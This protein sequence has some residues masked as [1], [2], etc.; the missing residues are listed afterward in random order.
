MPNAIKYTTGTESLALKKG[1]FYIG[2]GDVGKGPTNVTGY[3]NGIT[4]PSGGY[5]I[6][7]NKATGGPSIFVANNDQQL[8]SLTNIIAD[9]SYATVSECLSYYDNQP[10]KYCTNRDYESISTDGLIFNMDPGYTASY[11]RG[12]T[13]CYDTST[14]GNNG[15]LINSPIF[16]MG[17]NYGVLSFDGIDDYIDLGSNIDLSGNC[18]FVLW[19]KP[20]I[21][22]PTYSV[23]MENAERVDASNWRIQRAG[24]GN[25]VQFY[26]SNYISGG[27][28]ITYDEYQQ[29]VIV[30]EY[31]SGATGTV[32]FYRNGVKY[33]SPGIFSY[34][35]NKY[36]TTEKTLIGKI[37]N[38]DIAKYAGDMG[39]VQIYDRVLNDSEVLNLYNLQ[40]SRFLI[41]TPTPTPSVTPTVTP[42][43]GLA[44]TPTPSP[45]PIPVSS[46]QLWLDASIASS[47]PGSGTV[48]YDLSGNG[49]NATLF[50]GPTSSN[51]AILFDGSN[52]Y[53]TYLYDAS[54]A[55]TIITIGY[56]RQSTWNNY[57]GLGSSRTV[58]GFIVHND[59]GT[60]VRYYVVSSAGA[61]TLIGYV[62]PAS[63]NVM[64]MYAMSTNGTNAHKRYLD[65]SL[66]GTD[67]TNL[68]RGTSNN[69][70][71]TLGKDSTLSRYNFLGIK[72]H[73]IYNRQLSDA[74]ITQIYNYYF[75]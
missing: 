36:T 71:G 31:I 12:G 28:G 32:N 56:S 72:A 69:N 9:A 34:P 48:W 64:R 49:N 13:T 62:Y 44:P 66:V 68:S 8:I 16:S 35:L 33:F 42:T 45:L 40:S 22:W 26:D 47:Y 10:D 63:V 60:S 5:T 24:S 58:N 43:P 18:T 51:G 2:T 3:Y 6:Y 73:L 61:Y 54:A 17:N 37:P 19:I 14:G 39:M 53:A 11:P 30:C 74:E 1:N 59:P 70:T 23:I 29:I 27:I 20:S 15:T 4:P 25:G 67:T 21:N 38:S 57:G 65:G 75:S 50:N 55:M 7:L 41:P 46:L 52:D